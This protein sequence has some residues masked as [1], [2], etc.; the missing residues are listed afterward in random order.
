MRK[1]AL[2][3]FAALAM[4]S[5]ASASVI[6]L[7]F[8]GV[9]NLASVDD[10]YNGGTDSLG[11]SGTNYG[12]SFSNTS[13]GIVD[14][15]AGGSGNIANEPSASTVLFFL[16]GG[17]AT[18]NVAAGFQTGFSFFYSSNGAAFVRVYDGLNGT[19]NILAQL[20]LASQFNNNCGGDPNG[21]YCNWSPIGVLFSG[22]AYSVDFG[23]T[24]DRVAFDNVTFGSDR[25]GGSVVPEPATWAMLI[26]G[27][28]LVGAT[29]RRRR[30]ARVSA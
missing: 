22:T 25:P 11:N 16:S 14:S 21:D 4:A 7:T 9:G 3:S 5:S 1:F 29:M 27:F 6:T 30:M 2:A 28:G 10:F 8:E 13:L 20:D 23:G 17:A 26:T 19:G 24:A 12:I 18:M 15:D